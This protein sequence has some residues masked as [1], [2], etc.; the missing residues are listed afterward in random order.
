LFFFLLN[1][2]SILYYNIYTPYIP[3]RRE[4]K[5]KK[6]RKEER[7]NGIFGKGVGFGYFPAWLLWLWFC[8][9]PQPPAQFRP[10][11]MLKP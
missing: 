10:T 1:S 2:F 6:R 4:R 11:P 9:T 7:K 5:R 3:L 8:A